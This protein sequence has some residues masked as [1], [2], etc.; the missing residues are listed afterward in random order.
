M[1]SIEIWEKRFSI[2]FIVDSYLS[3]WNIHVDIRD[4]AKNVVSCCS[5][6]TY[7]Q[8]G[9]FSIEDVQ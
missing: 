3:G 9:E 7:E 8:T 5:G 1:K 2:V 4:K 6:L